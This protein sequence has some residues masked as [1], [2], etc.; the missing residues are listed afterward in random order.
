MKNTYLILVL[1]I[2]NIPFYLFLGKMFF[3]DWAGFFECVKFTFKPDILSLLSDEYY[4]DGWSSLKLL[5]YMIFCGMMVW[6]EKNLIDR[7]L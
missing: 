7:L 6:A 4:E 2:L 3:R 1:V 5:V